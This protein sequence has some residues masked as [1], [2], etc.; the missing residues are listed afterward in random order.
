MSMPNKIIEYRCVL[1]SPSD[2][3]KERDALT[4]L[5]TNWNAQI[6]KSLG[7]RV[8]LVKWE[9]HSLPIHGDKPQNILN[10]ELLDDCDLGIAIFWYRLGTPTDEHPSGSIEEIKL[11]SEQNKPI[12][13]YFSDKDIPQEAFDNEQFLSLQEVKN[14]MLK[15]GLVGR[16]RS[17]ENLK[18]QVQLNLTKI[19]LQL[20]SKDRHLPEMKQNLSTATKPDIRVIVRAAY[21]AHPLSESFNVLSIDVQNHSPNTVYVK[22]ICLKLKREFKFQVRQLV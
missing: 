1:I 7:A 22:N 12:L 21:V 6:G 2:V 16:Y 4:D 8:E 19:I 14:Q 3:K 11:L 5:V 9:S 17:I 15:E 18:E 13:I 20:I 10:N